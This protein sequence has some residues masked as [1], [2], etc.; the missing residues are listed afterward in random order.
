MKILRTPSLG[1]N[2]TGSYKNKRVYVLDFLK[3]FSSLSKSKIMIHV[4]ENI[5]VF[6]Q[7]EKK[8][9]PGKQHQSKLMSFDDAF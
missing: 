3:I 6:T 1:S 8:T 5:N 7:I 4:F 9:L 2:F